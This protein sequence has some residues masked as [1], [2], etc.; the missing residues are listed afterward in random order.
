[1]TPTFRARL[2]AGRLILDEPVTLPEGSE[3]ELV[4]AYFNDD[5]DDDERA[6]L[7]AALGRAEEEVRA[8]RNRQQRGVSVQS[9]RARLMAYRL[10]IAREVVGK[11]ASVE[12]WWRVA[13]DRP[14]D[15]CWATNSSPRTATIGLGSRRFSCKR[16]P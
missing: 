7:L 14:S 6:K 10:R 1:M 8:W 2:K 4:P 11:A 16:A 15:N 9:M 13:T 5:F 12:A 3:I